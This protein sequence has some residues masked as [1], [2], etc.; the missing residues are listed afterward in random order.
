MKIKLL[1]ITAVIAA[2][3]YPLICYWGVK[4]PSLSIDLNQKLIDGFIE[5]EKNTPLSGGNYRNIF[6]QEFD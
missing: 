4:K 5:F 2:I 3:I 6:N 1:I